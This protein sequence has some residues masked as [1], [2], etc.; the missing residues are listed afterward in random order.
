MNASHVLSI[1]SLLS[2]SA[3]LFNNTAPIST[4]CQAVLEGHLVSRLLTTPWFRC[5]SSFV[6]QLLDFGLVI[7][8]GQAL[9][10]LKGLVSMLHMF[11]AITFGSVKKETGLNK[12]RVNLFLFIAHLF[13]HR[14]RKSPVWRL[15]AKDPSM[16]NEEAGEL[17]FSVMSRT[18]GAGNINQTPAFLSKKYRMMRLNMDNNAEFDNEF[19]K[20]GTSGADGLN[21]HHVVKEDD[22]LAQT[23]I[24]F[25]KLRILAV[26]NGTFEFYV[27][28]M[29]KLSMQ[30]FTKSSDHGLVVPFMDVTK[31]FHASV[32]RKFFGMR[33]R[34]HINFLQ[35]F[36][37]ASWTGLILPS[38]S[39]PTIASQ[40]DDDDADDD[41]SDGGG[42]MNDGGDDD[43]DD[44]G[45][46][47]DFDAD[48]AASGDDAI[49]DA[50]MEDDLDP[51]FDAGMDSQGL[52]GFDSDDMDNPSNA[53]SENFQSSVTL[54]SMGRSAEL[55]L[56][57]NGRPMKRK[58]VK[59]IDSAA[60]RMVAE[61]GALNSKRQVAAAVNKQ[62][63]AKR[64]LPRRGLFA[65]SARAKKIAKVANAQVLVQVAGQGGGGQD[66]GSQPN[67][68][69][70]MRLSGKPRQRHDDASLPGQGIWSDADY[71]PGYNSED[72]VQNK[73]NEYVPRPEAAIRRRQR[74]D[75][76][77]A[78]E[79]QENDKIFKS[80]SAPSKQ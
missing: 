61:A 44:E 34:F 67:Q 73:D 45:G 18:M 40:D 1:L 22:D 66:S 72:Y 62:K 33:D 32:S 53:P 46:E 7:K 26:R 41:E 79:Q 57:Q 59:A 30:Q 49:S 75:R 17:S 77:A 15:F 11:W 37:T 78:L 52:N 3:A 20:Q 24:T 63:A 35:R 4:M 9:P 14:Q 29:H 58:M 80:K 68:R 23:L 36:G 13:W 43:D 27:G 54:A 70:S 12:Y 76:Q 47:G 42:G 55:F 8:S 31:N 48:I 16:W 21:G 2:A 60:M 51:H 74:R 5:L 50:K 25:F 39:V 64:K 6:L 38:S 71:L 65:G 28:K 10:I 56:K 19:S 69:R